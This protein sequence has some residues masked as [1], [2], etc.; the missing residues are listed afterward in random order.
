MNINFQNRHVKINALSYTLLGIG[1]VS[2]V[3]CYI[4]FSQQQNVINEVV[5]A[6]NRL[7][8]PNNKK[9]KIDRNS[10]QKEQAQSSVIKAVQTDLTIPWPAILMSL[11]RSKPDNIQLMEISI[12]PHSKKIRLSGQAKTLQEALIYVSA[13]EKQA[14]LSNSEIKDHQLIKQSDGS[15]VRF[16]IESKW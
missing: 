8:K 15:A 6:K 7:D 4:Q 2:L 11:E 1:L 3:V 16:E 10:Q 9:I 5:Y 14:H 12:E 13:L